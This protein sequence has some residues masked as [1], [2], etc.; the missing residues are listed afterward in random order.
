MSTGITRPRGPVQLLLLAALALGGGGCLESR[1][2]RCSW[3]LHCPAGSVCHEGLKRCVDT[4]QLHACEGLQEGASCR[5]YH[6]VHTCRR[7][8]PQVTGAPLVCERVICGD[9]VEEAGEECDDGNNRDHDGCSATCRDE[10]LRWRRL[11]V[12]PGKQVPEPRRSAA[13]AYD[14]SSGQ[15]LLFGGESATGGALGDTWTAKVGADSTSVAWVRRKPGSAPRARA[16]HAMVVDTERGVAVLFGGRKVA[17]STSTGGAAADTWEYDFEQ[18]G[19]KQIMTSRAPRAR[20]SAAMVWDSKRGRAVLVGGVGDG[21]YADTWVYQGSDWTDL[22]SARTPPARYHHLAAYDAIRD[23]IVLA[24]G[25]NIRLPLSKGYYATAYLTD[26][27]ELD[28][29]SWYRLPNVLM[30]RKQAPAAFDP[31]AGEVLVFGGLVGKN[32]ADRTTKEDDEEELLD[33][34]REFDGVRWP[35]VSVMDSISPP[36]RRSHCMVS[37]GDKG[38]VLLFGGI[39]EDGELLDDL[40]IGRYEVETGCNNGVIDE[41]EGCDGQLFPKGLSCRA[42]GYD[43]GQLKCRSC[44]VDTS[45]CRRAARGEDGGG[46]A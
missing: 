21:E 34:T 6:N 12:T 14:P 13:L 40:W 32:G 28:G 23:R 5:Y 41:G 1:V 2:V 17:G 29:T 18:G 24:G 33:D 27:W 30:A 43:G 9:N 20:S 35:T 4:V 11:P 26:T 31:C 37:L 25:F 3:G 46:D 7:G 19:W 16:D 42:L 45:A 22:D 44:A 15:A 36:A 8:D 10:E 38:G 39:A